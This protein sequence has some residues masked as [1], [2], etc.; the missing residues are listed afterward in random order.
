MLPFERAHVSL[1]CKRLSEP[2]RRLITLFGPRQTGNTTIIC[3]A[4]KRLA[5]M[6]TTM[7]QSTIPIL[8]HSR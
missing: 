4:L 1:V 5:G 7:W 3:Q 2:P 8:I 6:P